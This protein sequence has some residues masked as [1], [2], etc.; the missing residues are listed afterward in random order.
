MLDETKMLIKKRTES[1]RE[2]ITKKT[3]DALQS[4][5]EYLE[6]EKEDKAYALGLKIIEETEGCKKD[7]IS[8]ECGPFLG[9]VT[10]MLFENKEYE[11]AEEWVGILTSLV[12]SSDSEEE[13]F[14]YNVYDTV[15]RIID[16]VLLYGDY[17][18]ASIMTNNLYSKPNLRLI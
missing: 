10:N 1:E 4:I 11:E 15:I 9:Q 5:Y 2:K 12:L 14:D 6:K 13:G 17:E 18:S 16:L 8:L 7:D 3:G